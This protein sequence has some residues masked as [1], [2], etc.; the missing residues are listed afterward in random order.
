MNILSLFNLRAP[1]HFTPF[2]QNK[3]DRRFAAALRYRHLL[4][5][6]SYQDI[7]IISAANFL[8]LVSHA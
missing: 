1:S 5:L 2:D 6:G 4:S 3:C 8:A 7:A